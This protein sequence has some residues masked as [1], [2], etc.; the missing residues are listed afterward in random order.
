MICP[1]ILNNPAELKEHAEE[2]HQLS[3]DLLKLEDPT[4][5]DLTS[6][7]LNSMNVD[8][9]YLQKRRKCFPEH[10]DHIDGQIKIR[11]LTQMNFAFK[12]LAIEKDINE[13]MKR[14][15]WRSTSFR[16]FSFE[17]SHL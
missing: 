15:D 3:I 14:N 11:L 8:S 17:T 9:E 1:D 2:V 7:F 5:D 10:F 13:N 16:G 6:R 4:E 12:S